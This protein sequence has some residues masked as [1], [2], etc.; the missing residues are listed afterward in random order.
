MI[1][2]SE[3]ITELAGALV[4]AQS[5]FPTVGKN[6]T[7]PHFKSNYAD[8]T[9]IIETVRPVLAKHGLAVLQFPSTSDGADS[10]TTCLVHKSGQFMRATARLA[11]SVRGNSATAQEVGS[12]MTYCR[13]YGIQSVL[14]L[15]AEDDDGKKASQR[16]RPQSG[17]ARAATQ[18]PKIS[19][20]QRKRMWAIAKEHDFDEAGLRQIVFEVTGDG[21]TT[22][23]LTIADY[24]Q[25]IEKLEASRD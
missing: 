13:R 12:A 4:E 2:Q 21:E 7:N 5:E 22:A 23:N 8:L 20:A 10:L 1:E 14:G 3:S 6:S 16:Q 17:S 15:V 25:V 19:G 11:T 18:A 24:D 9:A